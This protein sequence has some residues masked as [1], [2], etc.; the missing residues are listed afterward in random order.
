MRVGCAVTC[1]QIAIEKESSGQTND[2]A[3]EYFTNTRVN[4]SLAD[5]SKA[6]LIASAP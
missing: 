2:A 3:I 4:L 1:T 5:D 6:G